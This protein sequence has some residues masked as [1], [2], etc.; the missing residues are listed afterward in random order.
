MINI[1]ELIKEYPES[2]ASNSRAILREYLQYQILNIIFNSKFLSKLSFIGGTA[3]RIV[4]NNQRFSEDLDFDNFGLTIEEFKELMTVIVNKLELNGY[5]IEYSVS[6]KGAFRGNIKFLNLLSQLDLAV[7]DTEKLLIQIDTAPHNFAYEPDLKLI[8]KFD[9]LTKINVTPIDVLL[10]QKIRALFER[11]RTLG[12][13]VYD[14]IFLISKTKP[15]YHYLKEKLNIN[16]NTELK[17]KLEE[18][19]KNINIKELKQDI[20]NFIFSDLDLNKLDVFK[21][22]LSKFDF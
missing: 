10:S 3:L 20:S 1:Q 17:I 14:I 7:C 6:E 9:V 11:N 21:D 2:L 8:K 12:R 5:K 19:F 15:N 4:Y 13:D 16:N 22:N 18:F